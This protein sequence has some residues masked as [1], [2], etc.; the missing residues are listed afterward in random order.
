MSLKELLRQDK[1]LRDFLRLIHEEDLRDEAVR[2]LQQKINHK[3][4]H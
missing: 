4:G 2:L 3:R 1:E